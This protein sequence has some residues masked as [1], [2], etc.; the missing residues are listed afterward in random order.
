MNIE[1]VSDM[2]FKC[3][4]LCMAEFVHESFWSKGSKYDICLYAY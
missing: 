3:S 1:N 2:V 4:V